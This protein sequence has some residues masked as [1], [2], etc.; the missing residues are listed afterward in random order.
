MVQE[1]IVKI[2]RA[3]GLNISGNIV[4]LIVGFFTVPIITRLLSQEL[5]GVFILGTTITY[6]ANRTISLGIPSALQYFIPKFAVEK[7]VDFIRPL[8][9]FSFIIHIILSL[10]MSLVLFFGASTIAQLFHKPI[11][12]DVLRIIAFV[13]PFI[14]IHDDLSSI[15][16]GL[17]DVK[18]EILIR[19][20]F[21]PLSR[22]ILIASLLFFGYQ[23][24]G[25]SFGHL[26]AWVLTAILFIFFYKKKIAYR[27]QERS[28]EFSKKQILSYS[29]PLT[30]TEIIFLIL[31]YTDVIMI[32]LFLGA[33]DVAAYDVSYQ[34]SKTLNF[35]PAAILLLL[36]PIT[37]ELFT[38]KD[39][40]AVG[41]LMKF[42]AKWI[43][44]INVPLVAGFL[45]LPEVIMTKIYQPE[46]IIGAISLQILTVGFFIATMFG[47]INKMFEAAGKSKLTLLNATIGGVCNIILN[48]IL[49]QQYGIAGTA[50]ATGISLALMGIIGLVE[51]Q[52]LFKIHPFSWN[53]LRLMTVGA[54][55]ILLYYSIVKQ[56]GI[57]SLPIALLSGVLFIMAY[58]ATLILT[59]SIKKED[60]K[61]IRTVLGRK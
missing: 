19:S 34:L 54:V 20:Y 56:I 2:F 40:P 13:I 28:K 49:I 12:E 42:I 25:I 58:V 31:S 29:V 46:Y 48:Y 30:F 5:Y 8:F 57:E 23:I 60:K 3:A 9:T 61:I 43:I 14:I 24:T 33:H 17:Q 1:N 11:L 44:V 16:I 21:F 7:K 32:G 39:I 15:F 51:M 4:K 35:L 27:F 37:T 18:T 36:K 52:L 55:D 38:K 53:M 41:E 47:P 59:K 50:I 10:L 45:V 6:I 22:I 26:F